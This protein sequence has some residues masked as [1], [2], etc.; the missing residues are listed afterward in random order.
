MECR[1][2]VH[3][4]L[5]VCV[6]VCLL[7]TVRKSTERIFMKILPQMYPW[8]RKIDEILEVMPIQE[9]LTDSSTLQDR[10][11][12]HNLAHIAGKTDWTFVKFLPRIL[13]QR[14]PR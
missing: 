13:G 5:S 11:F 10:V 2:Y 7:A 12:P 3:V 1:A 14:S 6:Y 9:F 8:T 4:C